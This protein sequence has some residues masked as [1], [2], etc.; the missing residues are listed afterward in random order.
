[1]SKLRLVVVGNGMAG[2]RAASRKSCFVAAVI[3]S[4]L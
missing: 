1:M 4:T 2:A 3:N